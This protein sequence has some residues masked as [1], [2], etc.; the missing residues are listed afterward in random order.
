MAKKSIIDNLIKYE[1]NH[2]T[3]ILNALLELNLINES[4]LGES[5]AWCWYENEPSE[6]EKIMVLEKIGYDL[7]ILKLE[8]N[9]CGSGVLPPEP[10]SR[11]PTPRSAAP[12]LFIKE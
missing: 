7:S 9:T 10:S 12:P 4:Y 11:L 3:D 1:L 8:N 6:A 2:L 5:A